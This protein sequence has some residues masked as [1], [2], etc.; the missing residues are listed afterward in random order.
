MTFQCHA[1]QG[2]D[3][4]QLTD[5]MAE[6]EGIIQTLEIEL[7]L[8]KDERQLEKDTEWTEVRTYGLAKMIFKGIARYQIE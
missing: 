5:R 8:I 6:Q 1:S 3:L 4:A 2:F 7:Q